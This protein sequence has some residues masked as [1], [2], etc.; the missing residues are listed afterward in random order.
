MP[1]KHKM[2]DNSNDS[3]DNAN[4]EYT[5]PLSLS[6]FLTDCVISFIVYVSQVL[7][8]YTHYTIHTQNDINTFCILIFLF[9]V[10]PK[11]SCTILLI[12]YF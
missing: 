1:R 4:L 10:S 12:F 5:F 2:A 9:F 6:L 11:I 3:N 8:F 7:Q